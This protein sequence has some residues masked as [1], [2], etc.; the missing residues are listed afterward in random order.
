MNSNLQP[1]LLCT[2]LDDLNMY[3]LSI[4]GTP[5]TNYIYPA[6]S[7]RKK[8]VLRLMDRFTDQDI[9]Q[10]HYDDIVRDFILETAYDLIKI[11]GIEPF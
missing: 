11:N 2:L 9:S 4:P 6:V 1:T 3:G 10:I 8:D 7:A 5:D